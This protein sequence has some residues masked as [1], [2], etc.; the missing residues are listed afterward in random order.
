MDDESDT[1]DKLA[2]VNRQIGEAVW[3][4]FE[5]RDHIIIHTIIASAHQILID[6]GKSA[7]VDGSIKNTGKLRSQEIQEFMRGVN[8]PYNFF[9]HA[10]KD[11][12]KEIDAGPYSRLTQHYIMDAIVMLQQLTGEIPDAAKVFWHWFVSYYP[13][14]F[15]NLP[16][17]GVIAEMQRQKFGEWSF[18]A[19]VLYLRFGR[20]VDDIGA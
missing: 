3:L 16:K 19:I 7:S 5:D 17:D 9:K 10:D 11:P 14:E 8:H 15:D 1:I 20:L 4:F 12:N 2:I 6:L 13:E 18:P